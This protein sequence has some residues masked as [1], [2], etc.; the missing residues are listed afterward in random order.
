MEQPVMQPLVSVRNLTYKYEGADRAAL[1]GLSLDLERSQLIC[2][3]GRN[4]SGKTTFA[5]LLTD[6]LAVDGET[7][8]KSADIGRVG[9]V[10]QNPENQIIASTVLADVAF[11]LENQAVDS[12]E[13]M[14]RALEELKTV[15]LYEKRDFDPHKLSGGEK[16]KLAIAGELV[17][18]PQ[19]LILDEATAM[20]DS[21][22]RRDL[23][24][25]YQDLVRHEQ[26]TILKISNQIADALVADRL[27][28]LDAGKLAY[29][30]K[31]SDI[32]KQQLAAELLFE[33]PVSIGFVQLLLEHGYGDADLLLGIAESEIDR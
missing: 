17:L 6:L 15:G 26:I 20:L 14:A 24:Q 29:D 11:G 1:S 32:F 2:L 19:L 25:L 9:M 5:R 4:G 7:I 10:L 21:K 16:Q 3:M 33:L 18:K 31:P 30:G 27:L 23:L 8:T 12:E 13:M 22:T 28:L